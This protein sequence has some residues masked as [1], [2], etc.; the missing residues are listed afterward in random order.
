MICLGI[1]CVSSVGPFANNPGG[2]TPTHISQISVQ[3]LQY[4]SA[5]DGKWS[6]VRRSPL[7]IIA[8]KINSS[9]RDLSLSLR[10]AQRQRKI[11]VKLKKRVQ[12]ETSVRARRSRP[13]REDCARGCRHRRAPT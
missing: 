8:M 13:L 10:L 6:P 3:C 9:F 11:Q 2:L 1:R 12:Q 7:A 5:L 4:F